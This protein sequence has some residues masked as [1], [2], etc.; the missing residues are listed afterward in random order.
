MITTSDDDVRI[1]GKVRLESDLRISTGGDVADGDI[2]FTDNATID[3]ALGETQSLDLTAGG[4]NISFNADLGKTVHLDQLTVWDT[5]TG[6][7]S[8]G[9]DGQTADND[10]RYVELVN[11]DGGVDLGVGS[12]DGDELGGIVF[13]GGAAGLT[14][15]TDGTQVRLNGAVRL[16]SDLVISSNS[17]A[18]DASKPGAIV[19]SDES[20]MDSAAGETNDLRLEA[21]TG[22]ITINANLGA[23]DGASGTGTRLGKLTVADTTGEVTFGEDGQ[24]STN[25][26]GFVTAINTD[27]VINLGEGMLAGDEV[28]SAIVFNGGDQGSSRLVI[29][30]S[31]DDVRI[32]GKVRLESDLRISTGGD[33]ADGDILFTDNATIDSAL[34]ETQSLDLT[35]GGGSISFNADLGKTVHLDQ[36]T[37]WD[38]PTGKVSFGRDGQTADNDRRYVELVNA[39]GGV[40]L[41]VGSSDGDELGGIVFNGGAAG[42]TVTT[43]G[44][45][46]RLNGAVRLES[47]LVISS[48]STASDAS[49][50]GAIVVSDESPMDSAAGET[51]DLRLEAGTGAITINANLGAVDGASGTGTRLGKLTVADTTGEVTF[52]EDGQGSTNDRGFVT[53]INTDDVINLGEGMLAG[54]EV[55]SAIVF[56]GGD[57]GSSR[58]VITTSDDDVRIN[59]KVRLE[60]DLRISTGG[61]VAD[62]DI[63]FTDNA[64]ID[65]ALG[66]TQSLDLTAG[67]GSISFNAD[68]GKTVHLDQLTVW[69]TPTGKVSFGRDGRRPT[70]TGGMW[71]LSTPTG[72]VDL[73]VGSSDGDELGGIVFNG[74][75]SPRPS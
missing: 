30:T 37:V 53:A 49:K 69:D 47:D 8:F 22:A 60:S 31:D 29:T 34:G 17:T 42:L 50:P 35:A 43:D 46:V 25:D 48:N 65:S 58:L 13:N 44:T 5:P 61:D 18:S 51:N 38:T 57:Q 71:S 10:R 23:V 11:A 52:G 2:L 7:V 6:K 68:L 32:N 74:G 20:P 64:T 27:D 24:G 63:L 72:G 39:N 19:V 14:V 73:G 59:G 26:R 9:R 33:V 66:E 4:G 56:N 40:D 41:G 70:T 55:P 16:E 75:T 12:S 36:L 62:G 28:P 3:S 15:T 67:G 21:G 54:D 1:N 45:Q